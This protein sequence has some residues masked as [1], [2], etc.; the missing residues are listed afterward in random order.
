ML[1]VAIWVL[2][3]ANAAYFAWTQGYLAPL[4]LAPE[5]QSEPQRLQ[6]QVRPEALRLINTPKGGAPTEPVAAPTPPP[7]A[8]DPV[9]N[10]ETT[11]TEA[12]AT[13]AEPAVAATPTL[14]TTAPKPP[15]P[16]TACWA[17][18]GFTQAQVDALR[19]ALSASGLPRGGWQLNEV[20]LGGRWVVYM[21]RYNAEQI[22]RK[23]AELRGMG[24]AFR[25][26]S[27]PLSPGLA[28]GT[29][30]SEASA[31]QAL[32]DVVKKGVRSA[33]VAQERDTTSAWNLRLPEITEAQR[34]TV[35]GLGAA[36]AGKRLQSC[37]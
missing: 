9:A 24:V 22:E 37:D 15:S 4:G 30:S 6:S 27:G 31:E 35:V 3:L 7:A 16:P 25:E 21:G 28:L 12:T 17:A 33:R 19:T 26:V 13:V 11:P 1:R 5:E 29:Y 32:Q 8:P 2:L 14:A 34:K 18:Y 36:L 20:Q 10:G 23:K